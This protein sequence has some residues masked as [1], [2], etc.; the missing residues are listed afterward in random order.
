MILKE[1]IS[2]ARSSNQKR[3]LLLLL[4]YLKENTDE[5]HT[6]TTA[7]L[8]KY[9]ENN[10][11]CA[12][13]KSIYDDINTLVDMGYDIEL[14]KG[15]SGGY[16]LVSR[17]FE[18]AEL[19]LLVDAVQSSKFI[20]EKKSNVLIKK[21]EKLTSRYEEKQLQRQVYVANRVK[22]ENESV[23][24]TIDGI[25]EAISSKRKISFIYMEWNLEKN[26]SPRKNGTRYYVEPLYLVWDDENYYLVGRTTNNSEIRHYRVDKMNSI[27]VEDETFS[28][29]GKKVTP[30]EYSK[31]HF[32]MF[33]GEEDVVTVRFNNSLI[34]VVLD[35]FGKDVSII[36]KGNEYFDARLKVVVSDQF[37]GWIVGLSG[38]AKIVAPE[39]VV[40]Q[41]ATLIDGIKSNL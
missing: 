1:G 6:V 8:L 17:E 2:M 9:L 39:S 20:S 14:K 33:G 5:N 13:R 31:A 7:N 23:L 12:E 37:F 21:L 38:K 29:D 18:L 4:D 35:R 25:H 22:T 19:K 28:D 40:Q 36:P 24:Y 26:L 11:V 41:Y 30:G 10:G 15:P 27:I 32:S 34:G 3:K 16:A